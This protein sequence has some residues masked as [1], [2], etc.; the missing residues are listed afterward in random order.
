M[1]EGRFIDMLR[2]AFPDAGLGDDTAVLPAPAGELL[3][4]ADAVVDGVHLD[5]R[6]GS[7]AQAAAKAVTANVSDVYAMGGEPVAVTVTAGL[8][9]GLGDED[10]A[11]LVRGLRAALDRYGAGLAGGDTVASAGPFFLDVAILGRVAAGRALRRGGARPGDRLVVTGPLGRSLAGLAVLRA[12]ADLPPIPGV[13][14]A[15]LVSGES[16]REAFLDAARACPIGAGEEEAA[17]LLAARGL[18]AAFL[19]A[20][21]AAAAH[22]APLARPLPPGEAMRGGVRAAIDV[23]DGL[24]R[25]LRNLCAQSGAGALVDE[26]ALPLDP[27]ADVAAGG[28]DDA[29]RRL[30]LGGGEEYVLL[31]AVAP[32]AAC[33]GTEIGEIR[34][35]ADGLRLRTRGGGIVPLPDL[36][37]EHIL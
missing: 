23:S 7:L 30:L 14:A 28:D 12:A 2:A 32:G 22:L 34:P 21:L 18:D 24:A 10:A 29:R 6:Y 36:G 9:A 3:F 17:A 26:A 1:N 13:P 5:L 35:A 19:P 27:P 11:D 31:L 4:A 16:G 37:W 20:L 15:R 33:P 8:P 25:D